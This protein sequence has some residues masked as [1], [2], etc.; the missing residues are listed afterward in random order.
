MKEAYRDQRGLP[1]RTPLLSGH[2]FA[3]LLRRDPVHL[4]AVAVLALGIGVNNMLFTLLNAHTI[5][6]LPIRAAEERRLYLTTATMAGPNVD[7]SVSLELNGPTGTG[8]S[9]LRVAVATFTMEA[10]VVSR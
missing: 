10:V 3:R 9:E 5:R 7:V 2:G 6:G 4:E 1:G 8:G